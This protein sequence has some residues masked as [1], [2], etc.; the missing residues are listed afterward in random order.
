MRFATH[1]APRSRRSHRSEPVILFAVSNQSFAIAAEDVQEIRSTDSLGGTAV[2]IAEPL[3]EKVHHTLERAHRTYYI[4]NGCAHFGLRIARPTLVL[5]MRQ[6]R[7]AVLV[8]RIERMSEISAVYHLPRAFAGAERRWY[9]GLAYLD[10][11]VIPVVA[12][13]G[14][15]TAEE[16]KRL[17]E[18]SNREAARQDLEGAVRA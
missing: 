14:F 12:P 15:L 13:T 1:D 16:F 3:L 6:V 10:D 7:V 8:D 2:E 9:R 17:D 11:H 18:Q 5:I 4:V